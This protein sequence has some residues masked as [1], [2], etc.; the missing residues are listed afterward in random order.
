MVLYVEKCIK[1]TL[2]VLHPW[3]IHFAA[4]CDSGA[5]PERYRTAFSRLEVQ[6]CPC[7][8]NVRCGGDARSCRGRGVGSPPTEPRLRP[9]QR[10]FSARYGCPQPGMG[11]WGSWHR[12]RH[13]QGRGKPGL[14]WFRQP[15]TESSVGHFARLQP[16]EQCVGC[17]RDAKH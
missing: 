11:L 5:K 8:L 6:N 7:F 9:C 13:V 14:P 15:P 2:S 3:L 16:R 4:Q 10:G 12:E 17:A 1:C